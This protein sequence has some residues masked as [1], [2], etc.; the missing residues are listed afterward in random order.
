[1]DQVK[2]SE[3]SLSRFGFL[4]V[5]PETG[6]TVSDEEQLKF[7]ESFRKAPSTPTT[8]NVTKLSDILKLADCK[9][10]LI[11]VSQ[12]PRYKEEIADR[13]VHLISQLFKLSP[14]SDISIVKFDATGNGNMADYLTHT[15]VF[16]VFPG[17]VNVDKTR[18]MHGTEGSTLL[19]T[20]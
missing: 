1:M 18:G 16:T 15:L 13:T 17:N 9:K 8:L 19:V 3:L 4:L 5:D 7:I 2:L 10:V 11:Q 6:E 14:D 12:G 20:E